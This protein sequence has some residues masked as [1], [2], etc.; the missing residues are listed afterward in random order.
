MM[1]LDVVLDS[2]RLGHEMPDLSSAGEGRD[3]NGL[4]AFESASQPQPNDIS[5]SVSCAGAVSTHAAPDASRASAE[6]PPMD[7]QLDGIGLQSQIKDEN[8]QLGGNVG[9]EDGAATAH[10]EFDPGDAAPA[11]ATRKRVW[12]RAPPPA[13]RLYTSLVHQYP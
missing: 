6:P 9:V 5:Q 13:C 10:A 2:P 11:S 1:D 8:G 12:V 7:G 4:D 3:N